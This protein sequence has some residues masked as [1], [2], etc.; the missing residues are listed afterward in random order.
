MSLPKFKRQCDALNDY[1]NIQKRHRIPIPQRVSS[2]T[3]GANTLRT[4]AASSPIWSKFR[5]PII[6]PVDE[7]STT[8]NAIQK[9]PTLSLMKEFRFS[10]GGY[11][12][13]LLREASQ[14]FHNATKMIGFKGELALEA[15]YREWK[16]GKY[17]AYGT[18]QEESP[19]F[20]TC[21]VTRQRFCTPTPHREHQRV[22]TTLSTP[23]YNATT[24]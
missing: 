9:F 11:T 6:Q 2:K 3:T 10:W 5:F 15:A 18:S 8:S 14:Y 4:R 12:R 21:T 7:M 20:F 1:G 19:D 13:T 24:S 16:W 22:N 23:P 17:R